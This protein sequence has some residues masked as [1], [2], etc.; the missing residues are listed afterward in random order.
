MSLGEEFI[1]F[2]DVTIRDAMSLQCLVSDMLDMLAE[3]MVI[4]LNLTAYTGSESDYSTAPE[5]CE[6]TENEQ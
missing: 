5:A 3:G 2:N 4:K 6:E 1:K